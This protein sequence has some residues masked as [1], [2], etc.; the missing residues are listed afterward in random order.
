MEQKTDIKSLTYDEVS[1]LVEQLGRIRGCA[2]VQLAWWQA[3]GAVFG[4]IL[5]HVVDIAL[6]GFLAEFGVELHPPDVVAPAK[7]LVGFV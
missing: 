7:G 5:H 4:Q 3:A 2:A 6:H 1:E